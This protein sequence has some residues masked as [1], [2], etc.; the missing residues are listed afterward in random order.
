MN[1]RLNSLEFPAPLRTAPDMSACWRDVDLDFDAAA[2]QFVERHQS[3]GAVHDMP[4]MDLRTWAV[5]PADGRFALRPLA[6][7]EPARLLRSSA[8]SM[9]CSRLGAPT[10]FI[11]R[12]PAPVQLAVMNWL[13]AQG[14][15]AVTVMLRLRGDEVTAIVSERYAPLDAVEL[16]DTLRAA[17]VRHGLLSEV[18]VRAVA[19]G[20]TDVLRLVL[21]GEAHTMR[22]GDVS[23]VGL[24]ISSSSFG[25]SAVHI[26]G[27]VFR[28]ICS[29]GL[30]AP[31]AMGDL[32]LRHVGDAQRLRDGVGEGVATALGHARG[33]LDQWRRAVGEYI[34]DVGDFILGLRELTQSE[35]QAVRAEL[36]ASKPGDLPTRALV[37]E[38]ANALTSVARGVEPARRLELEGIAGGV[39]VNLGGSR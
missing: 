13:L 26:R 15:Q 19:T 22:V 12:L 5:A 30:R 8:L 11:R 28:L 29:N 21:P 33:L 3:D 10:E 36:G 25:R 4:L 18:R 34:E 31:S 32:S 39:V 37:Y 14:D 20:V 1:E 27:T 17:L 35:Q 6:G 7:H 23:F 24:D 2:Q 38:V 9:L 16:V